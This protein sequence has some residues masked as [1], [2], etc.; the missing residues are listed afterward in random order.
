MSSDRELTSYQNELNT[1]NVV[2]WS[3]ENDL[4]LNVSKTH[5]LVF[6]FRRKITGNFGRNFQVVLEG[7]LLEP[8]NCV[9]YLGIQIENNLKWDKQVKNILKNTIGTMYHMKSLASCIRDYNICKSVYC[10][11]VRPRLEYASSV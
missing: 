7:S 10:T 8:E 5:E 3:K 1:G 4:M 11:I 2:S 6:D 9:K